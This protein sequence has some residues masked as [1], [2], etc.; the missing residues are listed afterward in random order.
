MDREMRSIHTYTKHAIG[1]CYL[2]LTIGSI[3]CFILSL[4]FI[5]GAAGINLIGSNEPPY[6]WDF[7]SAGLVCLLISC[8]GVVCIFFSFPMNFALPIATSIGMI[9]A[10]F[11]ELLLYG[12][13]DVFISLPILLCGTFLLICLLFLR[14]VLR[15]IGEYPR[16]RLLAK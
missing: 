3:F 1:I 10:G 5:F 13:W 4:E 16:L 11:L 2:L 12:D 8:M 7:I 6:Q 14:S 15:Q 9:F